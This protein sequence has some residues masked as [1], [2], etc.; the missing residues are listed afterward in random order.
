MEEVILPVCV[1]P[2]NGFLPHGDWLRGIVS[3]G[4]AVDHVLYVVVKLVHH[5]IPSSEFARQ[6]AC[7][8]TDK[9]KMDIYFLSKHANYR[10]IGYIT[11]M[12]PIYNMLT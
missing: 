3:E 2:K 7:F 10:C 6:D 11:P 8:K 4:L 1:R 5:A 12:Y 9:I